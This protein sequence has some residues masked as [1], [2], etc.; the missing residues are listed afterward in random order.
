[1]KIRTGAGGRST[2]GAPQLAAYCSLAIEEGLGSGIGGPVDADRIVD[3]RDV[4]ATQAG[5]RRIVG[6]MMGAGETFVAALRAF[7]VASECEGHVTL[8]FFGRIS[9]PQ[10]SKSEN[11]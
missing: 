3:C 1:M 8:S 7:A 4:A 5:H 11:R 2:P 9:D 10:V 6:R